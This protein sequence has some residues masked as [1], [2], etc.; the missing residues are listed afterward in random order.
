M[1]RAINVEVCAG[2]GVVPCLCTCKWPKAYAMLQEAHRLS[3]LE[4]D[5]NGTPAPPSLPPK[6]AFRTWRIR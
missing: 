6:Y 4:A 2:C 3:Q 5:T 1:I